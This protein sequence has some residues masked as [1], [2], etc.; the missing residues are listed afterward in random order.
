MW[1]VSEV[2]RSVS[3]PTTKWCHSKAFNSDM[4]VK[5]SLYFLMIA[6]WYRLNAPE[7]GEVNVMK[8]KYSIRVK[9]QKVK[10]SLCF[11]KHNAI[12]YV[13]GSGDNSSIQLFL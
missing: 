8:E 9:L 3:A 10:L 13:W 7:C 5:N 12:K 4:S 11:V 6:S 2:K 1:L